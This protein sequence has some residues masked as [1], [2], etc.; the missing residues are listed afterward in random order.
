MTPEEKAAWSELICRI[1][2]EDVRAREAQKKLDKQKM[3]NDVWEQ[4]PPVRGTLIDD[5]V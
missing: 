1:V 4:L 3:F 5:E 2:N